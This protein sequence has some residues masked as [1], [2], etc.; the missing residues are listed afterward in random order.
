MQT[1]D[2]I[3]DIEYPVILAPMF[4]VTT[5]EMIKI[6]LDNGIS[7]A[8]PAMNFRKDGD[9]SKAIKEI[10]K[11]SSKAFGINLITNRS[12]TRY[13]KQL[14][15][16]LEAAPAYVISSLGNPKELIKE[17]HKVGI[18]VFCDVVDL[19]YAKK[20]EDLGADA[21]IAVNSFAGGHRGIYSPE[22]LIGLLTDNCNIPIINAGGVTT[23]EDLKRIM[24][25]GAAGASVGTIFIASNESPVSEEYKKA[26]VY[27]GKED[28]VLTRKLSGAN[29][30]VI[31]TDY[32]KKI[33]VKPN[34]LEMPI[35]KNTFLKKI[36]KSIITKMGMNKL[37]KA[38]FKATYKT[39]WCA[40]ISI[41][42]IK[43]IRPLAEIIKEIVGKRR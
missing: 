19:Q 33:G 36:A 14:Y 10:K 15:E 37:E 29:T 25:L 3:L 43:E 4:L 35:I 42:S 34:I 12:N 41:E 31:N 13:K 26:L 40:G 18:K 6:A 23:H 24:S 9:L 39:F 30:T 11:H 32:V 5:P 38:A 27:Y 1:L 16:I 20:A 22:E 7:G 2:T 17:A 28:I 8:I 21:L